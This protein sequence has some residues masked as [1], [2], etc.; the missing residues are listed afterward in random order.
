MALAPCV[1]TSSAARSFLDAGA[2]WSTMIFSTVETAA[3]EAC[4]RRAVPYPNAS[5]RAFR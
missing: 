4:C 2:C 3:P 5:L 1:S